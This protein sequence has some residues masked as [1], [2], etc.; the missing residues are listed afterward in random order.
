MSNE[1]NQTTSRWGQRWQR[2]VLPLLITSAA[3]VV[4][5]VLGTAMW[6]RYIEAPWTRD[7]TVRADVVTMAA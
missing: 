5:A 4:A 1:H 3:V 2:H 7:G 6:R